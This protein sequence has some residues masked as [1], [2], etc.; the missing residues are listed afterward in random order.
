[1]VRRKPQDIE[2]LR[3]RHASLRDRAIAAETELK[4]AEKELEELRARA[5]E[6]Y[7]TDDPEKL[8]ELLEAMRRENEDR[9]ATYEA[10]LDAIEA[11]L[12]A[13]EAAYETAREDG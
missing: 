4:A 11:D 9:R 12:N 7:G 8:E 1:M 10:S 6:E 13:V 3:E 5:R 2:T